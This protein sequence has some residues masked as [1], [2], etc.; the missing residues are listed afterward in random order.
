VSLSWCFLVYSLW[1]Q[2]LLWV[3]AV[4]SSEWDEEEDPWAQLGWAG[5][6]LTCPPDP[7]TSA[8][9][10]PLSLSMEPWA[11]VRGANGFSPCHL[12]HCGLEFK[13]IISLQ[14]Q[15]RL[16]QVHL[17]KHPALT[18]HPPPSPCLKFQNKLSNFKSQMKAI[19]ILLFWL[20]RSTCKHWIKW[21]LLKYCFSDY[22]GPP[23]STERFLGQKLI[24]SLK[25]AT[26][27]YVPCDQTV[28]PH[29]WLTN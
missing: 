10:V 22:G 23:V 20:W 29:F 21:K 16:S 17:A 19:K 24:L 3:R 7:P 6:A 26:E 4:S 12:R 2:C 27:I 25:M 8:L 15:N 5:L 9:S 13:L 14:G 18:S 11:K 1:R 28:C